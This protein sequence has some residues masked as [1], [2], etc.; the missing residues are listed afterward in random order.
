MPEMNALQSL[1]LAK[2]VAEAFSM[3]IAHGSAIMATGR[4]RTS[5]AAAVDKRLGTNLTEPAILNI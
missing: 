3:L 1:A 5:R 4:Q 2:A